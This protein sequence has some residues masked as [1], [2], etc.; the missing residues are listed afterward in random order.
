MM[1]EAGPES[2]SFSPIAFWLSKYPLFSTEYGK[3]LHVE[4][5]SVQ[6]FSAG[7]TLQEKLSDCKLFLL[8]EFGDGSFVVSFAAPFLFP[9]F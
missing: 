1:Y 9:T 6:G 8:F 2:A 7:K 3:T 4:K 5:S